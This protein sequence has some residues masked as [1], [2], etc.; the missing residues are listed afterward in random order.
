MPLEGNVP[1]QDASA[2]VV[3][4]KK[5][6][7]ISRVARVRASGCAVRSLD[8]LLAA[9]ADAGRRAQRV[10]CY[11]TSWDLTHGPQCLVAV[12]RSAASRTVYLT[13]AT[14]CTVS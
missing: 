9:A 1:T 12:I 13:S 11:T 7:Q 4:C 8:V 2:V 5:T 10:S 3:K 6:S 14:A